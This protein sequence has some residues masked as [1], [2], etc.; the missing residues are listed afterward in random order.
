MQAKNCRRPAP[1]VLVMYSWYT[2][3]HQESLFNQGSS[4]TT[5]EAFMFEKTLFTIKICL[6]FYSNHSKEQNTLN[7]GKMFL[8]PGKQVR[9]CVLSEGFMHSLQKQLES[10]SCLQKPVKG[11]LT[12]FFLM[13]WD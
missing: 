9:Q 10:C 8:E 12:L 4:L 1:F 13:D 7:T 11:P 3:M 6:F 5:T 2:Q